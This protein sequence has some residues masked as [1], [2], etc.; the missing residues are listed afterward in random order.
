MTP[1]QKVH[2][3]IPV[4]K[5]HVADQD[6]LVLTELLDKR[7]VRHRQFEVVGGSDKHYLPPLGVGNGRQSRKLLIDRHNQLLL[8]IAG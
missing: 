3:V 8:H 2:Q 7:Y 5:V 6:N 1:V 4:L